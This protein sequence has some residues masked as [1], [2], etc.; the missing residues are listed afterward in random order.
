MLIALFTLF[1]LGG[2]DAPLLGHIDML[3]D[4]VKA[5]I[6]SEERR[7]Q[8][9]D[10]MKDLKKS[11]KE[12]QKRQKDRA[13]EFGRLNEF[14]QLDTEAADALWASMLDDIESYHAQILV[15]R[16]DLKAVSHRDEWARVFASDALD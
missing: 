14:R 5:E 7:E 13:N 8:A 12:F 11:T 2:G 16:Q 10:L 15:V 9:I 6:Q 4:N 1:F 3:L